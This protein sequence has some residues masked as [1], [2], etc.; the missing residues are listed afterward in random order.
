[1]LA[2][3]TRLQEALAFLG[4]A[5]SAG[6]AASIKALREKKYGPETI[7]SLQNILDPYCLAMVE[8]NP[9]ARVKV[10][11]GA[12]KAVLVKGGW[13]SFLVKVNNDAGINAALE[14]TS[15][16][17]APDVNG[18]S[19]EARVRP[20]N[21]LTR[22]QVENRFMEVSMYKNR[23]LQARLSGLTLEYAVVQLYS[24]E[25]GLREVNLG[26]NIGQGTQDIG[27]RNAIS[28]L[29]NSRP[30]IKVN[31]HIKDLRVINEWTNIGFLSIGRYC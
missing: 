10:T 5:L 16:N 11:R 25:A 30:A 17:A 31:L 13:S 9:E 1:M 6:D 15:P 28:I 8:I 7:T 24:R 26:F 19:F 12:A 29:F 3:V 2:Q 22:G 14:V 23:P 20:E 21:V 27:F 4:N 18:S